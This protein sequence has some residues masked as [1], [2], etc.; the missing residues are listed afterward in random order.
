MMITIKTPA[1]INWALYVLNKRDDNFHNI[2]SLMH[3]ISLYDTL[4]FD[5][6]KE[7]EL[8]HGMDIPSEENIV[9]KAAAMIR[10]YAGVNRGARI[11]LIKEIPFGAGLGGGSSDAACALIGLNKLWGLGL[12]EDEMRQLSSRLGSD[13][14]F[15][16][17]C[18]LAIAEGKGEILT[19]L[20][21][22]IS[23][24]LL[25]VKPD[26]PISTA[27]AY[28][29]LD[30]ARRRIKLT[31]GDNKIDN[32]QLIYKALNQKETHLLKS[33][34]HN[35]FEDVVTRKYPVI[36]HI[37]QELINN[38]A[39]HALMSGSGSVVFGLFEDRGMAISASRHFSQCWNKVVE[40][41][42][43]NYD[44]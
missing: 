22:N 44:E 42:I 17:D 9:Y 41:S 2:I 4:I 38:G 34:S 31:N 25:L 26:F 37:K 3:C 40:T 8:I 21:I 7:I 19:P 27:W 28:Q 13:A 36:N 5:E 15:F 29:R 10:E 12:S 11:R 18:P 35:D 1:K 43:T 39:S 20:T 30:S 16:F 24:A 32:I 14:Q 23:Y 33:L 6:A